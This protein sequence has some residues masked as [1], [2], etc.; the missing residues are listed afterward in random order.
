MAI[1]VS[2]CL[3]DVYTASPMSNSPKM[4]TFFSAVT[5]QFAYGAFLCVLH[6]A[7]GPPDYVE[8][9]GQKVGG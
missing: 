5:A 9:P 8:D 6:A 7:E 4:L 3:L 2:F 1:L